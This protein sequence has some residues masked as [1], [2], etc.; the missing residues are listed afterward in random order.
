MPRPCCVNYRGRFWWGGRWG[1]CGTCSRAMV[2]MGLQ[3]GLVIS[4]AYLRSVFCGICGRSFLNF[5]QVDDNVFP[6]VLR[7]EYWDV[8]MFGWCMGTL[9]SRELVSCVT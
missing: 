5:G 4:G 6:F 7:I 3:L 9:V 1:F 8:E 2:G